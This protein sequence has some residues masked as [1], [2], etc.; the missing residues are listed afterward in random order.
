V[1]TGLP[2]LLKRLRKRLVDLS[3]EERPDRKSVRP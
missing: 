2:S 3:N 1:R